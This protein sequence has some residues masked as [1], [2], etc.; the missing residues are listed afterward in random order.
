MLGKE[1]IVPK[2]SERKHSYQFGAIKVLII[3]NDT[4][5]IKFVSI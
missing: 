5:L 1:I 4:G 2:K 3:R